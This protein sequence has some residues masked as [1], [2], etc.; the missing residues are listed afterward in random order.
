MGPAASTRR[1]PIRSDCSRWCEVTGGSKSNSITGG[2]TL[3]ARTIARCAIAP[4]PAISR[5]CARWPSSSMSGN[6]AV[7]TGKPPCRIGSART[8]ATQPRSS[9]SSLGRELSTSWQRSSR[10]SPEPPL[11]LRSACRYTPLRDITTRANTERHPSTQRSVGPAPITRLP[12]IGALATLSTAMPTHLE[13]PKYLLTGGGTDGIP[14][15][16]P[17]P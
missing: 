10:H 7:A 2:I 6:E 8:I 12:Q 4:P 3:S 15:L 1:R 9:K 17:W 13:R 11:R 14:S 5:S 16:L